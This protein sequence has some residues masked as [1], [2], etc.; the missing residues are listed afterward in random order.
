MYVKISFQTVYYVIIS[1]F[2]HELVCCILKIKFMYKRT[3]IVCTH[4]RTFLVCPT[5]EFVYT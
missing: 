5:G 1:M 3:Y 4:I 2:Y